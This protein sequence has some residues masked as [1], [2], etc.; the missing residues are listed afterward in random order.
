M[1]SWAS[2][3]Q[4]L[5]HNSATLQ[6]QVLISMQMDAYLNKEQIVPLLSEWG[7]RKG[8]V[9]GKGVHPKNRI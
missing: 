9:V 2:V 5:P 4:F 3:P 6:F 8:G 1:C 7:H